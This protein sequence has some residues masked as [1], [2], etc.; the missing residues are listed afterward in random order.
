VCV[1]NLLLFF[2]FEIKYLNHLFLLKKIYLVA[3]RT[4]ILT[5]FQLIFSPSLY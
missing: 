2:I 5:T 4:L 1:D 3:T